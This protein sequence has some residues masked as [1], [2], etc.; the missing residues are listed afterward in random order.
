MFLK[1]EKRAALGKVFQARGTACAKVLVQDWAWR[2]GRTARRPLWLEQ[3]EL[4]GDS[5]E[6]KAGMGQVLQGLVGP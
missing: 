2:V 5:G 6:E 4:Q 3:S 1:D